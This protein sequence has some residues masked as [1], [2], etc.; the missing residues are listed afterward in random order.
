MVKLMRIRP[1]RPHMLWI[2][3][4]VQSWI[5]WQLDDR[6]APTDTPGAKFWRRD[7]WAVLDFGRRSLGVTVQRGSVAQPPW[8]IRPLAVSVRRHR[9]AGWNRRLDR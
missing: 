2:G 8:P 5:G 3:G 4:P 6:I 7:G 1:S 9:M